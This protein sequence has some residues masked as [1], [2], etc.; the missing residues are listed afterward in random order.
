MELICPVPNDFVLSRLVSD[1]VLVYLVA[2]RCIS[3]FIE[4]HW[5]TTD[6]YMRE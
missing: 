5:V 2:P 1:L 3:I 4:E 6:A